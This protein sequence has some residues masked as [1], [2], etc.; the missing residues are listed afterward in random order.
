MNSSKLKWVLIA[1][2]LAVNL[3]FLFEY[4]D[5][6]EAISYYSEEEISNAVKVLEKNNTPVE[7]SAI[8]R[9]KNT[10]PVLK[11]EINENYR[12]KVADAV[13]KSSYASF[14]LPDGTGYS[15]DSETLVFFEG[16]SFEYIYKSTDAIGEEISAELKNSSVIE[17]AERY[18]TTLTEKFFASAITDTHKIS[19]KAVSFLE[20]DG[21]QYLIAR[22]MIDG[23]EIDNNTITATFKGK[24][25]MRLE[26]NMFFSTSIS[27]FNTDMLDPINV[28]FK[29][30][31]SDDKIVAVEE[32]YFP[33]MTESGS[34]YLTPSYKF[35]HRGGD[36]HVWDATS[37]TQRY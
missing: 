1:M 24:T 31:K 12:G 37:G 36:C 5:Y 6:F 17:D 16:A 25:L 2:F 23:V 29:T 18:I 20:K 10:L 15:N 22:Q 35:T 28:L 19:L 32:L 34:F 9:K 21:F 14:A 4:K 7:I 3:F 30:E 11:L 8:P 26:G 27:E 13:M 33:V